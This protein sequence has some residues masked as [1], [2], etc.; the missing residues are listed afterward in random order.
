MF[1]LKKEENLTTESFLLDSCKATPG[2]EFFPKKNK[3]INLEKLV[4]KLRAK[5]YFIEK[6]NSPF[7]VMIKTKKGETTIFS[8]LKIIIRDVK[9]QKEAKKILSELLNIINETLM[10]E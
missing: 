10:Q 7:L 6:D 5:N 8:S 1:N 2:F 9:D 4:M 3:K